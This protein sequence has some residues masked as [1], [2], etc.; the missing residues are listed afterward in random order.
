MDRATLQSVLTRTD[1]RLA[2]A[3]QLIAH[4]REIVADLA[5]F[6][7]DA[8][9]AMKA[10]VVFE[11]MLEAHFAERDELVLLMQKASA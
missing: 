6:G 8:R 3:Q 9:R 7:L 10:L 2:Q 4:Q 5:S 1:E 11:Q